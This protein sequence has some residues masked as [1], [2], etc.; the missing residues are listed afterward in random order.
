M[1][2]RPMSLTCC[3]EV[4]ACR[5]VTTATG[6][7]KKAAR[8]IDAWL[9]GVS[10]DE[11]AKPDPV[12]ADLLRRWYYLTT[13]AARQERIDIDRRRSTFDEVVAGLDRQTSRLEAQRC[14]SCGNCFQCDGCYAACPESAIAKID[15]PDPYIVNAARCTG[16]GIC[17]DQ[18]PCGAIAM[19]TDGRVSCRVE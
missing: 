5:T 2:R 10:I 18:C 16:C 9:R 3:K 13:R 11:R 7:G 8:A 1:T 17:V 15:G 6:H 19:A 14:L 4:S 12:S